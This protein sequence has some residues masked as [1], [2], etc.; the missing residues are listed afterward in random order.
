ME[1]FLVISTT[2]LWILCFAHLLLTLALIRRF[3]QKST[4]PFNDGIQ[5]GEKAPDFTAQ[6]LHGETMS[7]AT[8][9]GR[10]LAMLFVSPQC[11]PCREELPMYEAVFAKAHQ[12]GVDMVLVSD[13][14]E[15]ATRAFAEELNIRIPILIA[16]YDSNPLMQDYKV[17][18]TPSFCL[19]NA[20]GTVQA[21]GYPSLKFGAWKALV[22]SWEINTGFHNGLLSRAAKK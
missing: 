22:D 17:N 20:D 3:N 21:G 5:K 8:Y 16:P 12:A 19:V 1:Q 14:D 15:A 10:T 13:R 18:G 9:T 4:D 6:T 7:L 2:L 11:G